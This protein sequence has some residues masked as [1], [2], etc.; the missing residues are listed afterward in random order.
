MT[1]KTTTKNEIFLKKKTKTLKSLC[2]LIYVDQ[3]NVD[4]RHKLYIYIHFNLRFAQIQRE[5][6][7][8]VIFIFAGLF[9]YL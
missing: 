8:T 6:S 4:I 5:D 3:I 9:N 7:E 1:K 2:A